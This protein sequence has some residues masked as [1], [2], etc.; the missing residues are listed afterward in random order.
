[1]PLTCGDPDAAKACATA[2]AVMRDMDNLDRRRAHDGLDVLG[3]LDRT[4]DGIIVVVTDRLALRG[5]LTNLEGMTI[6]KRVGAKKSGVGEEVGHTA[7][8]YRFGEMCCTSSVLYVKLPRYIS[9]RVIT[10]TA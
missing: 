4:I 8:F 5:L 6:I 1:M 7:V 3:L 10:P 9:Q 2:A